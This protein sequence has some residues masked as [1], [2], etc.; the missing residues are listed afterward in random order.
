[1]VC[2][3]GR[4]GSARSASFDLGPASR[5][6]WP[7]NF[8]VRPLFLRIT[9]VSPL[10]IAFQQA[11][12]QRNIDL[13]LPTL[14]A[15]TL[16]VVVGSETKEGQRPEWFLTPSPTKGR[17]CVTASEIEAALAKIK[18][19][20]LRVSGAQLLETLPVGIEIVIVYGNGGD[21]IT[22]EQLAWYRQVT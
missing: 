1:M 14:K 21:Y 10:Q 12:A 15:T 18:W 19:P 13:V 5:P 16:Y 3:A 22:R 8:T 2:C 7:R 6:V 4:S 20:K 9:T 11:R 17:F